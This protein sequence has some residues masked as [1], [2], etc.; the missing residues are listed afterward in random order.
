[1]KRIKLLLAF[2]LFATATTYAQVGIGTAAPNKTAV[3]DLTSTSKGLLIPRVALTGINDTTTITNIA[4]VG[5]NGLMVYNTASAGTGTNAV[6]PGF[7]FW[8][9]GGWQR[10]VNAGDLPGAVAANTSNALVLNADKKTITSTVNGVG[11]TVALNTLQV[12]FDLTSSINAMTS[13]IAGIKHAAPIINTNV[14]AIGADK[15]ITSTIN[16]LASNALDI[17][18]AVSRP[19]VA[20]VGSTYVATLTS[21]VILA[22]ATT[23]GFTVTLPSAVGIAGQMYYVKKGDSTNNGVTVIS[24]GGNIDNATAATGFTLGVPYQSVIV[25][26]DGANWLILSGM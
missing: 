11:A 2:L 21:T 25:V 6:G 15:K 23:A 12:D 9:S 17:S 7:Y 19:G 16:G 4:T 13:D 14:L 3:L 20:L 8:F 26:S 1:M 22:N 24:A 18:S 10:L 5:V